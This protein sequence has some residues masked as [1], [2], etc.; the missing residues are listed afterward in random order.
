MH[1]DDLG[2]DVCQLRI[3][4]PE[5]GRQ[6]AP[7][8]I[9]HG[10]AALHEFAEDL[11]AFRVLQIESEAPLIAIEGLVKVAVP[12]PEKLRPDRTPNTP[13]IMKI[14]DLDHLGAEIGKVL[15]TE[16]SCTILLDRDDPHAGERQAL[17]RTRRSW[18]EGKRCPGNGPSTK[19]PS[20]L[21]ASTAGADHVDLLA[22]EITAVTGVRV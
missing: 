20:R 10:I 9:E 11:L 6:V 1:T 18:R 16:G 15:G 4:D 22:P 3:C 21:P 7:K 12:R 13:A 19:M 14:L 17:H 2:I 8:V 5:L